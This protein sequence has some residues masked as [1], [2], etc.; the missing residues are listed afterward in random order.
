[1]APVDICRLAVRGDKG[2]PTAW[3]LWLLLNGERTFP[4]GAPP[5]RTL[6]PR[7]DGDLSGVFPSIGLWP[8]LYGCNMQAAVNAW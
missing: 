2:E 5:C 4:P 7:R 1:M 8:D 3:E 6:D